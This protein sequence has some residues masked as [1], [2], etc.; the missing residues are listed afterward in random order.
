[1]SRELSYEAGAE[2]R[3]A[4]ITPEWKL[5]FEL[6]GDLDRSN[7]ELEDGATF[8]ARRDGW[9]AGF[10]AVRSV[11][12]HWS[13]GVTG[14]SWSYRPD[15][16]DLRARLAPA[17]EWNLFPYAEASRRQLVLRYTIGVN[18]FDYVEETVHDLLTETRLDHRFELGYETRRPWGD[19]H[20]SASASSFLH[21]WSRHRLGVSGGL[22]LRL[23]RG[24]R[25]DVFASY[26]RVRDQIGLPKGDATDEEIFLRL[27]ELATGYEASIRVGLNYTF[28]SILNSVVNPRF[29]DL[30]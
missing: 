14:E 21:D 26:S 24:L 28:G 11:G 22:D 13:V 18:Y 2:V 1:E 9:D 7:Y 17:I 30:D 20:V 8:T 27:R 25:L 15:N 23:T 29:A 16:L 6:G 5:E 4:R 3:A 19:A 10:L 12:P